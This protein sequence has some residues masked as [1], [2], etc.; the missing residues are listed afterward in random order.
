M[1]VTCAKVNAALMGCTSRL[2][3]S[4]MDR[5]KLVDIHSPLGSK[6]L[7]RM[8]INCSLPLLRKRSRMSS[9]GGSEAKPRPDVSGMPNSAATS[10]TMLP[11]VFFSDEDFN[12]VGLA[13]HQVAPVAIG[14][15]LDLMLDEIAGA[16]AGLP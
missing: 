11:T 15:F 13:L 6:S 7:T 3:S 5:A 8:M 14:E 4:R 16:A 2:K 9:R 12:V 1:V 10:S